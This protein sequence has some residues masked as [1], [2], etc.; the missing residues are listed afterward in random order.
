MPS[1]HPAAEVGTARPPAQGHSWARTSLWQRTTGG[2]GAAKSGSVGLP[3]LGLGHS[4][5]LEDQ[6]LG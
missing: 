5:G 3:S 2:W 4:G 6:G 1:P